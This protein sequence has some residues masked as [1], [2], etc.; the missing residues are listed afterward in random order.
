MEAVNIIEAAPCR[1]GGQV[2]FFGPCA[3]APQSHWMVYCTN[4]ACDRIASADTLEKAIEFWN[5]DL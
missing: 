3:Y 4:D 2:K 5:H 1:C